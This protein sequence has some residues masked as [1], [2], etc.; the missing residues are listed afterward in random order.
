MIRYR[1][2]AAI[3]LLP[4]TAN[5][6]MSVSPGSPKS[7]HFM[8]TPSSWLVLFWFTKGKGES[9]LRWKQPWRGQ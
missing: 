8:A 9:G 1:F 2:L 6:P 4:L 5:A 3:A 7:R